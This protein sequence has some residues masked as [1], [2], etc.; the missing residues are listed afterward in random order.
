MP[1]H[2]GVGLAA[3]YTDNVLTDWMPQSGVRWDFADLPLTSPVPGQNGE[4][5]SPLTYARAAAA[6]HYLPVFSTYFLGAG[7][8]AD[9]SARL[10]NRAAMKT[11]FERFKVLFRQLGSKFGKVAIVHVEPNLSGFAEQIAATQANCV[12]SSCV[13]NPRS[14]QVAVKSTGVPEVAGFPNTYWGLSWALAHLRDLYAPHVLLAVHLSPWATGTDITTD[15]SPVAANVLGKAAGRFAALS[16]TRGGPAHVHPYDLLFTDIGDEDAGYAQKV[17]HT[18]DLW[19]DSLNRTEPNFHRWESYVAAAGR[20][21]GLPVVVWGIPR[22]TRS[23]SRRT[24]RRITTRTTKRNTF[25]A[26]RL[27]WSRAESSA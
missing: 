2:L 14:V 24:T 5:T 17:D 27:S 13:G 8:Q 3:G 21:A 7:T 11:F 20:A 6:H 1:H 12:A 23:I 4:D 9:A 18:S 22:V 15:T 19:W 25:S 10:T 16:A 26:T